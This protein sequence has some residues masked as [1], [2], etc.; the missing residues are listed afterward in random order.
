VWAQVVPYVVPA[1]DLY[2]L[3]T[4]ESDNHVR[5]PLLNLWEVNPSTRL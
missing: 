2:T 4:I 3:L 5:V 1:T